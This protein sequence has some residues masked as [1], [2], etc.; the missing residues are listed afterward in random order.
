MLNI[1]Y[2]NK[3]LNLPYALTKTIGEVIY[4]LIVVI[5]TVQTVDIYVHANGNY[6]ICSLGA[7]D[8]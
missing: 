5:A 4:G 2:G 6:M 7:T 8:Y 1:Q 3:E